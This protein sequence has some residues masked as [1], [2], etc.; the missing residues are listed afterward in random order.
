VNTNSNQIVVG[1]DGSPANVG[2]LRYAVDVARRSGSSVKL[3]HV[4]PD[5]VP[6]T[7]MMPRTPHDLTETGTAVLTKAE[8]QVH[9]LA[10][11]LGVEGWLHHGA[12][13]KE[14]IEGAGDARLIVVGRDSRSLVD[15]L[16]RGDTGIAVAA[17][18]PTPVVSVPPDWDPGASRGVVLVGLKSR[19]H[20]TALL[21]D[22][23]VA[24]KE[25][26]AKLRLLH[27][28]KLPSGYDDIIEARVD[29]A[30][31][32]RQA[33]AEMES[34]LGGWRTA[35][36][37]VEVEV[38]VVHDH[39]AHALVEA[40]RDAAL[41]VL[42]RRAHGAPAGL[43]LGGTARSVLRAAHCPVRIVPADDTEKG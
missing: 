4:V 6:I 16:L 33:T 35:Y 13:A 24:A 43:H 10:P 37:D 40:S 1:V 9:D 12:R 5:Y 27:A 17:R 7:I 36:P 21:H 23:F 31:W 15:R 8:G 20:A 26:D 39:A 25:R 11:D 3:I 30:K 38:V 41:V 34:L 19:S 32:T 18:A 42:G 22:A 29:V 2:A 28:W 14:I